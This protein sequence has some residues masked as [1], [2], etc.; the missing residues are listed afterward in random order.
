MKVIKNKDLLLLKVFLFIYYANW[1]FIFFFIPVYLREY[2]NFSIGMIGTL[3]ALSAFFGALSQVYVGYLSDRL[4]KRKPFLIV[5]SLILILIYFLVFPRLNQFLG[6]VFMY[7]LIGIFMNSLTTLSNVLIFDYST[8]IGTGKAF[9]SVRVWAPIGFLIMML[10]IGFYPKLTE[11]NIMFPLISLIFFLGLLTVLLLKEPELKTGVRRIEI[12]DIQKF[13]TRTDVRNFLI[14]FMIYIFAM[15]GS[16]GN[17]NLLIKHLGG[18]NSD[19]SWALSVCSITEIPTTYLWGYLS[20]K[21][22]RLPLLLFTSII[23]PIRVFLYSLANK[24]LDVILIQLFTHSL[25]FA[26][27]IT[28]A[29]VYINDLVSEEERASAQGILS[30][31]MAISQT[32]T[33]L[34]SGNV[35]D[36]LGLKGMYLFLTVIALISTFLGL[37]LLRGKRRKV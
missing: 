37:T 31:A 22:G 11:P 14:F 17:V 28:V 29:V 2:K 16:A 15:G 25:T 1:T 35:A 7:S 12:K 3:S 6:F 23:L 10:T 21:I 9:A 36:I 30:M 4:R 19:I 20:D 34:I 13:I 18:T 8:G 24:A 33:A 5:S 27:M 32:L 26:I